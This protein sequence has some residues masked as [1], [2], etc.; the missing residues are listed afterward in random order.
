MRATI[1]DRAV[2]L[3][4][5]DASRRMRRFYRVALAPDLID[6]WRLT[7]EWGRIGQPGTLR[8]ACFADLARAQ[9]AAEAVMAAKVKRG[10]RVQAVAQVRR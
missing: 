1:G 2:H 7:R 5:V 4:R 8:Q 10:Y 9:E 3:V 6:G